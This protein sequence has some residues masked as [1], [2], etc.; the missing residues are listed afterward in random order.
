MVAEGEAEFHPY[1]KKKRL[2][3]SHQLTRGLRH[4]VED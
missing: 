1:I 3:R 2:T 4:R